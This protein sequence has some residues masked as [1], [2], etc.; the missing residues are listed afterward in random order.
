MR[1]ITFGRC[2]RG[3]II[4]LQLLEGHE[5]GRVLAEWKSG[6]DLEIH[7]YP[8]ALPSPSVV[9][10]VLLYTQELMD[11]K[12][13]FEALSRMFRGFTTRFHNAEGQGP[14]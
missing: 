2:S 1:T 4:S 3:L 7:L 13:R 11:K 5:N 12:P 14:V 8:D 9:Y 6:G 10:A